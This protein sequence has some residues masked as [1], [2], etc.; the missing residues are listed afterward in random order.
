MKVMKY[1]GE[2]MEQDALQGSKA[3]YHNSHFLAAMKEEEEEKARKRMKEKMKQRRDYEQNGMKIDSKK[4]RPIAKNKSS[5][6]LDKIDL[7]KRMLY[8]TRMSS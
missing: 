2:N 5:I 6:R 4:Q 8:L 3:I 7:K 1:F